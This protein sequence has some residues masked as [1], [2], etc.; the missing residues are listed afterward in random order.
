MSTF[1]DNVTT[2]MI[3]PAVMSAMQPY[4]EELYGDPGSAYYIGQSALVAAQEARESVAELIGASAAEVVF[5]SG[6]TES[7]NWLMQR[8]PTDAARNRIVTTAIEDQSILM[9]LEER[10]DVT[11]TLIPVDSCGVVDSAAFGEAMG[12]D[13][14]LVSVQLANGEIGTVQDAAALAEAAHAAGLW[15]IRTWHRLWGEFP[16]RCLPWAWIS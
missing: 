15:C 7:N 14:L 2:T 9:A 16:C 5:T 4:L 8:L 10:S 1:M 11:R 6:A 12:A 3:D 13:V